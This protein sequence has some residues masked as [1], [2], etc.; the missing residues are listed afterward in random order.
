MTAGQAGSL[1]GAYPYAGLL[2]GKD[3]NFYGT[4]SYGGAYGAG[5]VFRITPAGAESV[6][7]SF[8]AGGNLD[9]AVPYGGLVQDSNGNFYGT[10]SSGGSYNAGA[11][12]RITSSGVE[13]VLYSFSGALSG[14]TDG[15]YPNAGLISASDGNYYGTTSLGGRYGS[16]TVFRITPSGAESVLY[17]FSGDGGTAGSTDG[18]YP[19]AR[20][21]LGSDGNFY[22]TTSAGGTYDTGAVFRVTAAG[23]GAVLYFVQRQRGSCRQPGWRLSVR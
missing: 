4:A 9:A 17:S 16:G 8:G 23:S 12:F 11:V 14:S 10:T 13:K 19:Y 6:I 7:Y 20:L 5:A 21:T 1:D 2:Q 3:G 15:A 18:V 22:G